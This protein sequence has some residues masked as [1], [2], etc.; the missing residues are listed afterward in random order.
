VAGFWKATGRDKAIYAKLKLIGMRKT[1]VFYKGRA[2]NGQKTDWIMHEYRLE[3][4]ENAP[5]QEEGWVVCR[6]FK[7]RSTA[8][9]KASDRDFSSTSAC[10][11]IDQNSSLPE[12]DSLDTKLPQQL[13]HHQFGYQLQ[14]FAGCKQELEPLDYQLEHN[15]FLQLPQLESPKLHCNANSSSSSAGNRREYSMTSLLESANMDMLLPHS[16]CTGPHDQQQQ[17]ISAFYSED[18]VY[19]DWRMLDKFVASQLSQDD[20]PDQVA[21]FSNGVLYNPMP[22]TSSLLHQNKLLP[23][24]DYA[25]SNSN[26][27]GDLMW[28]FGN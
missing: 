28:G 23:E 18:P 7:K 3:T 10:Y 6:A 13:D 25:A 16:I 14:Q 5:P 24:A 15:P 21:R 22:D 4:N 26:S 11:E 1:L 8:Q 19:T 17:Q 2:P 12:L 20:V 9:K 27:Y